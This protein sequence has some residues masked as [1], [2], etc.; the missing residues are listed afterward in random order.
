MR[1]RRERRKAPAPRGGAR[2]R[3]VRDPPR[4]APGPRFSAQQP[5]DG[6]GSEGKPRTESPSD[7][8]PEAADAAA[9]GGGF[10]AAPVSPQ[11]GA[12]SGG[13]RKGREGFRNDATRKTDGPV[14]R[15]R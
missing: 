10:E 8:S 9:D 15:D 5:Q 1:H 7:L 6:G 3:Q 4:R 12:P 11:E 13:N 14:T 2:P